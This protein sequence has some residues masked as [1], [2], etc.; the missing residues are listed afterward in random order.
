MKD[1]YPL[2]GLN[3]IKDN[4]L[5]G[6]A[7]LT[8]ESEDT[9]KWFT[10]K[11]RTPKDGDSKGKVFWVSVLNG[12]D[13][14]HSYSY[15]GSLINANNGIRFQ[16]TNGSKCG[17]DALSFKAFNFLTNQIAKSKLNSKLHV[18]HMG[19]CA[20]CGRP[21]TTPESIQIGIGPVCLS[22]SKKK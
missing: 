14:V 6:N 19:H 3:T 5:G 18:Y 7:T 9:G 20:R 8:L 22:I 17:S 16:I 12:P 21:L 2:E 1:K 11:I 4:L 10:Y 15:I 13:N